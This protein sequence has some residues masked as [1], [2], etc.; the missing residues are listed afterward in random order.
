MESDQVKAR[1]QAQAGFT[2]I[3]LLVVVVIAGLLAAIAYGSYGSFVQRGHRAE[4][5]STLMQDATILERNFTEANRYDQTSAGNA[6]SGLII[7]QS[8]SSGTAVYNI[9]VAFGTSQD[10]ALTA[11]PVGGGPMANDACGSLT[12]NSLGQQG[13][14]GSASVSECWRK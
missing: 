1:Y 14:T 2:L 7:Q 13:V 9:A 11:A 8:P 10:F 3:E 4:A 6:T 12:L 5:K